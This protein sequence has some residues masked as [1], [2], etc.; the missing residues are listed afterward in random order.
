MNGVELAPIRQVVKDVEGIGAVEVERVVRLVLDVNTEKPIKPGAAV[1]LSTPAS[2]A[3]QVE[4]PALSTH[5][6][7]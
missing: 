6:V 5:N 7:Y 3:V 1:A 4:Q 2:L